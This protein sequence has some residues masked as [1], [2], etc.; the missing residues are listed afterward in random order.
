[1]QNVSLGRKTI[2]NYI[3]YVLGDSCACCGYNRCDK[4]LEIHHLIPSEKKHNFGS[5][6]SGITWQEIDPELKNCVL[7]CANCH[8]EVHDEMITVSSTYNA[9]KSQEIYQLEKD[10]G[11]HTCE[12][13]GAKVSFG[14]TR[15]EKCYR[16]ASRIVAERPNRE[17]LKIAIR[18]IPFTKIGEKYG[19][20][21]NAIR[22]WCKAE[23]LP[24]TKKE[25]KSYSN[26]EWDKI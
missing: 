15:C 22:K 13:C 16:Q 9:E 24:I 25:I 14:Y 12:I 7:L 26:E 2:K 18:N 23:N 21:D 20:S 19:V 11:L 6:N 3:K 4:A 10:F 1:M 8:R 5:I 17:E